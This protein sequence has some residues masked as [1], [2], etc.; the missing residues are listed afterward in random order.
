MLFRS[1]VKPFGGSFAEAAAF[2]IEGKCVSVY[3]RQVTVRLPAG[4]A[5]WDV[6]VRRITEDSD[7]AAVQ[8]ATFWGSYTEIVES[9]LSYRNSA[10]MALSAD[11]QAFG[12]RLPARKYR[13]PGRLIKVPSNR[14]GATRTYTGLWDG[15]FKLEACDNPAWILYDLALAERYGMGEFIAATEIDKWALYTIGQYC[16]GL[17]PDGYGGTEARYTFNAV[18]DRRENAFKV[19]GLVAAAFMG[20]T[21]WGAGMVT[22]TQDSPGSAVKLATNANVVGGLFTYEGVDIAAQHSVALVTWCNPDD[23]FVS[24]V[25]VVEDPVRIAK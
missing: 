17:V 21:W 25:E 7:A 19:L 15:T 6:R 16:D 1:D 23:L 13:G 18:I 11:A 14:D 9:R 3:E 5:P 2:T 12:S 4:G 24:E 22:A 8:N 10:V 20:V